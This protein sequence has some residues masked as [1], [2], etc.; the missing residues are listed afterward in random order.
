MKHG[1]VLRFT[2]AM[3]LVLVLP[4]CTPSL[5]KPDQKPGKPDTRKLELQADAAYRNGELDVSEKDYLTLIKNSPEKALPWYRLGNIYART[6]R[7]EAAIG[8]YR[9]ALLRNPRYAEAWYNMG[10]TQLREAART[11]NEMQAHTESGAPL[12]DEGKRL[13]R[14]I[15][16]IIKQE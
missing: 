2:H 14:G 9:Q 13:L 15:L 5:T 16:E 6:Q 4:A 10:L 8:A 11:F 3:V 12:S 7:P 1:S